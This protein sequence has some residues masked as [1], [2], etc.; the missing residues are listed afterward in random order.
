M[1]R[2]ASSFATL[3]LLFVG[4]CGDQTSTISGPM[5]AASPRFNL[6]GGTSQQFC[7]TTGTTSN[8]T[9]TGGSNAAD[10][11]D[12]TG[13]VPGQGFV[14]WTGAGANVG[15][16]ATVNWVVP[17]GAR[18]ANNSRSANIDA[19]DN[20]SY[21]YS[22]GFTV[23]AGFTASLSGLVLRDNSVMT[24]LDGTSIGSEAHNH[25]KANF[26]AGGAGN[27]PSPLAISASNIAAG[28]HTVHFVVWNEDLLNDPGNGGHAF[29]STLRGAANPTGIIFCFTVI[30]TPIVVVTPEGC[31]PGYYKK[32]DM[33]GGNLLL[34]D[35]FDNDGTSGV[36][37]KQSLDFKG[38]P[39]LQDAKN[40]LLRQAA[41]AYANSIRLSPNYPLTTAQVVAQT[42]AALASGNRDTILAFSTV[43]DGYNN[44]EGPRC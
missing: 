17:F 7:S 25:T 2:I 27:G 30:P 14:P 19:T 11:A 24:D 16:D 1:K 28:A 12:P 18:A 26:G 34:S 29:P 13:F 43:L 42:N 40:V 4:A 20:I 21:T 10:L 15:G 33:P 3:A 9:V 36:T 22:I 37:L 23:P 8:V 41:A 35:V 32:H 5:P 6:A 38:G 44:L 31:S 39:S